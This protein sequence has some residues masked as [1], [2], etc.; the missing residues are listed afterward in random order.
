MQ[1]VEACSKQERFAYLGALG[2]KAALLYIEGDA[3][4]SQH[5]LHIAVASLCS[6]SI[7]QT[8]VFV[9]CLLYKTIIGGD[10]SRCLSCP[11]I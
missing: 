10:S 5:V 9:S 3:P 1:L 8:T 4:C 11:V 7:W 6:S 2:T